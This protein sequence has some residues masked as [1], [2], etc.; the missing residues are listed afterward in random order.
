MEPSYPIERLEDVIGVNALPLFKESRHRWYPKMI[1]H[2]STTNKSFLLESKRLKMAGIKNYDWMLVLLQPELE[3]VDPHDP[4]LSAELASKVA[5]E[6]KYNPSYYMREVVRLKAENVH[7]WGPYKAS[8]LNL[9]Q[10]FLFFCGVGALYVA[11]RQQGKTTG[12]YILDWYLM[13]FWLR[14]A[15]INL[16]TIAIKNGLDAIGLMKQVRD[17]TP[18][19][20]FARTFADGDGRE[21]LRINSRN[22][23][24]SFIVNA[25]SALDA[26]SK[27]RGLTSA[28][29]RWDEFAYIKH[30][31]KTLMSALPGTTT[32][33]EQA[34]ASGLP[35]GRIYA[36]TAGELD[37]A[38]GA[39]AYQIANAAYPFTEKLYDTVSRRAC[40]DV[41]DLGSRAQKLVYAEFSYLQLGKDRGWLERQRKDNGY[42]KLTIEKDFLNIW[43]RGS[44]AALVS[45]IHRD[46]L[47]SGEQDPD[48]TEITD[49]LLTFRWYIDED[50]IDFI[51]KDGPSIMTI[52]TSDGIGKDGN[53]I[54]LAGTN[55]TATL[56]S[57]SINE[58]NTLVL[59]HQVAKMLIKYK[60]I[61]LNI[62]AKNVA[63]AFI[64]IVILQ[65]LAA[66]EDPFKRIYNRV[67]SNPEEH[68]ALW[69]LVKLPMNRRPRDLY[70]KAKAQFGFNTTQDARTLLYGSVLSTALKNSST[71]V[72]DKQ[73]VGELL[74]LTVKNGRI[75]HKS[76]CHDDMVI[77]WLLCH[78]TLIYGANLHFYGI[79]ASDVM[80]LVSDKGGVITEEELRVKAK[81]SLIRN[82]IDD[83]KQK[84][85]ETDNPFLQHKFEQKLRTLIAVFANHSDEPMSFTEIINTIEEQRNLAKSRVFKKF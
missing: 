48:Y 6:C 77:S 5:L 45:K 20:L 47:V 51:L 18:T 30:L 59:A 52:D 40:N 76:G 13:L 78:W 33:M 60:R 56:M 7:G 12:I 38:S 34:E 74:G 10:I 25:S 26:D 43:V 80:Q 75:D 1:Y 58:V 53:S 65:L 39:Y 16:L 4:N 82:E 21:K 67:V 44:S 42:S 14:N 63:R 62:E 70:T 22:N 73:L 69:E 83:F 79:E 37:T 8:R 32:A 19:Y 17:M 85:A 29:P 64:D 66:G 81:V 31:E 28:L 41:V 11:P 35:N 49:N 27:G 72:K 2:T 9:A 3:F 46:R 36:T 84:L 71:V 61:L 23:E 50:E 15:R 24:W 55:S 57:T 54:Y 68:P